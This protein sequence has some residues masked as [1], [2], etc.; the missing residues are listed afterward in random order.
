MGDEMHGAGDR[1]VGLG[2]G[3]RKKWLSI[4]PAE[5]TGRYNRSPSH[6]AFAGFAAV[7]P[8]DT[9]SPTAM[10]L[11]AFTLPNAL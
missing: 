4:S 2:K 8:L 5:K 11:G 10:Q 6:P 9:D 1:R 3:G 7:Q